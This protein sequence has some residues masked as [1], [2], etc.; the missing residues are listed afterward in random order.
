MLQALTVGWVMTLTSLSAGADGYPSKPVR[1]IVAYAAGGAT[2]S[3]ARQLAAAI[4]EKTGQQV[5]VDNRPGAASQIGI[6]T[7]LGSPADGYTVILADPSPL[8]INPYVLKKLSYQPSSLVPVTRIT[9]H[10]VGLVVNA[11]SPYRTVKDFVEA[12]KASPGKL[13]FGHPG[14]GTNIHLSGMRFNSVAGIDVTPIPYRGDSPAL[15][16]LAGGNTAAA[17]VSLNSAIPLAQ[18]GKLRILGVMSDSR[19]R[20]LPDVPTFVEAGYPSLTTTSWLAIF[21]P[22]GTPAATV[23]EMNGVFRWAAHSPKVAEWMAGNAM[24]PLGGTPQDLEKLVQGDSATFSAVIK[25][26]GLTLD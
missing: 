12:A 17:W 23:A 20:A 4:T 22:T 1:I 18:S 9:K 26:I 21:A 25:Q 13:S 15:Q 2:D 6:Q 16:E 7:L 14:N 5:V 24:D 8:T 19:V 3:V 10:Y 11:N